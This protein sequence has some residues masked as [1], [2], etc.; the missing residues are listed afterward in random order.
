VADDESLTSFRVAQI[1]IGCQQRFVVFHNT[2]RYDNLG[3]SSNRRARTQT[4]FSVHF[5]SYRDLQKAVIGCKSSEVRVPG[6][7]KPHKFRSLWG[8]CIYVLANRVQGGGPRL[9]ELPGAPVCGG[10]K[11]ILQAIVSMAIINSIDRPS[12]P[13]Y[14][15]C[16]SS[17]NPT[18]QRIS[19]A[20]SGVVDEWRSKQKKP[21]HRCPGVFL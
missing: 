13:R 3:R 16:I 4:A 17:S 11:V 8:F 7:L 10:N 18:V 1:F 19:L 15:K 14:S 6:T 5:S 12:L 2:T 21:G 20:G 9:R